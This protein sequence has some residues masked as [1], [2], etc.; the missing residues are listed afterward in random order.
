MNEEQKN[1]L[2]EVNLIF[3]QQWAA[4]HPN[5]LAAKTA[6]ANAKVEYAKATG[7]ISA[8]NPLRLNHLHRM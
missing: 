2:A 4:A 7:E 3:W 8:A 6:L 5:S 1:Q